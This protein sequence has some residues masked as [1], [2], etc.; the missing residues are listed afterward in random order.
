[1]RLEFHQNSESELTSLQREMLQTHCHQIFTKIQA[2][3]DLQEIYSPG[4]IDAALL[5]EQRRDSDDPPPAAEY[6]KLWLP[7][8]LTATARVLGCKRG[9]DKQE[10]RLRTAQCHDSLN[11]LRYGLHAKS[12]FI[13]WR[14]TNITGQVKTTRA[15]SLIDSIGE[16]IERAAD[17]YRT[18][19][20]A[21]ISL[22]DEDKCPP[23]LRPLCDCDIRPCVVHDDD[24]EARIMLSRAGETTGSR[25]KTKKPNEGSTRKELSWIWTAGVTVDRSAEDGIDGGLHECKF[26]LTTVS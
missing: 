22:V 4:S 7:S 24:E 16:R 8:E 20:N 12:Y 3:R 26:F 17:K 21:A 1:M 25:R 6:L 23:D 11:E 13:T 5:D 19:Y 9:L 14:N 18:A 10:L 2:L 15:N